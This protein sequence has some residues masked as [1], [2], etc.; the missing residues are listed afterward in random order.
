MTTPSTL[1]SPPRSAPHADAHADPYA[2]S[3]LAAGLRG[4]R[5]ALQWRLLVWWALLLALPTL[6]A[7]LPVWRLLADNLD[8]SPF[9][10]RLAERLDLLSIADLTTAARDRY[11]DALAGGAGVALVLTLLLAPLLAAMTTASRQ[12][13]ALGPLLAAGSHGYFRMLR[14]LAWATIPLSIAAA[15]GGAA[16]HAADGASG[17]AVLQAD[18]DR[19]NLL[20]RCAVVLL[21]L[22]VH[23][24]LDTGRALLAAEPHRHSA[25]LAWFGG[26]RLLARRPFAL[27]GA[28]ALLTVPGLLL[29]GALLLARMHVPALGVAGSIASGILTALPVLVLGWMRSAR[30]LALVE[31]I[32]VR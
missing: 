32:L 15:L 31:L 22:L 24:T 10:A 4:A 14:M 17:A 3:P 28:Y 12:P 30:L 18:G 8:Y 23:V 19:A 9:A 11:A 1:D 27:F 5:G 21:A 7:A 2:L 6:V 25:V 29:A 13:L 26:C 16:L 20:A